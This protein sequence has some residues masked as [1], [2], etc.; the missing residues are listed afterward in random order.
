MRNV[1]NVV[2]AH[3]VATESEP[4]TVAVLAHAAVEVVSVCEGPAVVIVSNDV[5]SELDV[6]VVVDVCVIV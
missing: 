2:D 6:M 1:E 4:D 3:V 5:E